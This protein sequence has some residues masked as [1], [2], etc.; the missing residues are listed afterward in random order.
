MLYLALAEDL[1]LRDRINDHAVSKQ[2]SDLD[3]QGYGAGMQ[4][5]L[6]GQQYVNNTGQP[7]VLILKEKNISM[8]TD[9]DVMNTQ[10]QVRQ[11]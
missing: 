1:G 11:L 3:M 9:A 6:V 8:G 7:T 10:G 2:P 5:V 4:H